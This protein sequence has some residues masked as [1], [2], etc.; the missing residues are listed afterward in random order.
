MLK[1]LEVSIP[2]T[3]IENVTE[4]DS[5]IKFRDVNHLHSR[6]YIKER[7]IGFLLILLLLVVTS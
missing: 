5:L 1:K 2:T 3:D 7:T 4:D 6:Q